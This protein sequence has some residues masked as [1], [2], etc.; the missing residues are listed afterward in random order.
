MTHIVTPGSTGGAACRQVAQFLRIR[1]KPEIKIAVS[2]SRIALLTFPCAKFAL[3]AYCKPLHSLDYFPE[4]RME[5]CISRKGLSSLSCL[6]WCKG[7]NAEARSC[8]NVY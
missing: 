8:A 3:T 6:Q 5:M 4:G 1:R 2:C 7:R